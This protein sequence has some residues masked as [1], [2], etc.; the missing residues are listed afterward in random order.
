VGPFDGKKKRVRDCI[1]LPIFDHYP[2]PR[3]Q[4]LYEVKSPYVVGFYGSCFSE[5]DLS[6]LMEYMD[7]GSL[8]TIY[9]RLGTIPEDMLARIAG[10]IL[11][12]CGHVVARRAM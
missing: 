8:D 10:D 6:I 11:K 7:G 5:A 12:V 9:R 1:L 2:A 4:I 3:L